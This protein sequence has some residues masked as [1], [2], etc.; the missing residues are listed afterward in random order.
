MFEFSAVSTMTALAALPGQAG[1]APP[2]TSLGT[3]W[4]LTLKG[5][6]LMIPLAAASLVALAVV[7][8]RSLSLRRAAIIP[9]DELA[10]AQRLQ[11]SG[12]GAL[13]YCEKR[14]SP[15]A[16]LLTAALK[17]WAAAP[18]RREQVIH[19]AGGRVLFKLRKNLRVL[20]LIAAI[21]P[22][23][24]LLGTIFGMI[25]AFSTVAKSAEALGKTEL[26]ATGIYEAMVTT[27]AGLL[28][29]IPTLVA[30]HLLS[31]RIERLMAEL[32]EAVAKFL[33]AA[34]D[35]AVRP[36]KAADTSQRVRSFDDTENH[37]VDADGAMPATTG[38]L[39]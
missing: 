13:A 6:V 1:I 4:D 27:A 5:G 39:S 10:E 11:R 17:H 2:T 31:G 24:G 7:I 19:Q 25:R 18:Q 36:P 33:D 29:A 22:L 23:L 38:S 3:V 28:V 20:G 9:P 30:H 14:S 32:D 37:G 8:E 35:A 16:A 26:L 12:A 21:A 15:L 34:G